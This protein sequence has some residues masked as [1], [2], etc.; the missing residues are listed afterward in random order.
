ML[1]QYLR[2]SEYAQLLKSRDLWPVDELF[3][4]NWS[5]RGQHAEFQPN[6]TEELSRILTVRETLGRTG[7]AVVQS[8]KCRRV[9]LAR[10]TI[11]CYNKIKKLEVVNEIANLAALNHAHIVRIIGS[12]VKG[13]ELSILTYP[14]ADCDLHTFLES[15]QKAQGD[16]VWLQTRGCRQFLKC[17]SSALY[18]LHSN[19]V[20]HMDIKPTN[21]LVRRL[22]TCSELT[23]QIY[24]T[25]F[26]ISKTYSDADAAETDGPTSFT[27]KYAAPEVIAQDIRGLPADIFSLGCV[28]T[29]ILVTFAYGFSA[30]YSL[31]QDVGL[32]Q[33]LQ[34]MLSRPV[35]EPAWKNTY[36]AH[37]STLQEWMKQLESSDLYQLTGLNLVLQLTSRMIDRGPKQRPSAQG[38]V[39]TFGQNSCC[40]KGA[41]ELEAEKSTSK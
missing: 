1:R 2:S 11:R 36:R 22:P 28:F 8:V 15:T 14:V 25:D 5:N 3:E 31:G 17:L 41:D 37:I 40:V 27:R 26:G 10:K 4:Q 35:D 20:K 32:I 6:E 30:F 7:N 19:S 16:T 39:E 29:E 13:R 23:H 21:I 9:L 38:L 34:E 12:Y 33:D 24:I 18:H